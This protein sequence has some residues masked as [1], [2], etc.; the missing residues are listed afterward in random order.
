MVSA[1]KGFMKAKILF[2][3]WLLSA[4]A[5]L[6]GCFAHWEGPSS[7]AAEQA[8]NF[9][10]NERNEF[11]M[12]LCFI[13]GNALNCLN[14]TNSSNKCQKEIADWFGFI[15]DRAADAKR[16]IDPSNIDP[17]AGAKMIK[18]L[19]RVLK[20]N[21]DRRITDFFLKVLRN[22]IH[23]LTEKEWDKCREVAEVK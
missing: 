14:E 21:N 15:M 16:F 20:S 10:E 8:D 18:E 4:L 12:A 11:F 6:G 17:I 5:I 7:K 19:E 13:S 9:L 23:E 1:D 2:L 22:D 3:V